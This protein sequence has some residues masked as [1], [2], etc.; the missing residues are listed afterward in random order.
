MNWLKS[1]RKASLRRKLTIAFLAVLIIPS[2]LIGYLSF[3]TAKKEIRSMLM[4]TAEENI[5]LVEYFLDR[6]I[7]PRMADADYFAKHFTKSS[8]AAEN[9]ADILKQLNQYTALHGDV[10]EIFVGTSEGKMIADT[11]YD[12]S[13]DPRNRPWYLEAS[14]NKETI[15]TE[16]YISASTNEVLV[17][18][19][20]QL[21]DGSGVI[22]IDI[23]LS[24]IQNLINQ[25]KIGK[26]GYAFLV[27]RNKKF[28]AH[29]TF[30]AGSDAQDNFY[31]KLYESDN[32]DFSYVLDGIDKEMLFTTNLLTGWKI[33]GTMDLSEV[34]SA[35]RQ[36]LINTAVILAISI[37]TGLIIV[38]FIIRSII[39]PINLLKQRAKAISEGDL[40]ATINIKTKDEIG[41][42]A[43]SFN[44]MTESLKRVVTQTTT[45]ADHVAASAEQLMASSEQTTKATEQVAAAIE[46]I[47]EGAETQTNGVQNT[48]KS[49]E[50]IA[51]GMETIAQHS[52]TVSDLTRDTNKSADAGLLK[53][54]RTVKQMNSIFDSVGKS[55]ETILTLNERS[56]EIGVILEV[57]SGISDQTNL[58]ALN[59]AIEAARAGEHGKG[60]A[61]VADEVRKLAE[62]SQQA[63]KQ[64][65]ELIKETQNDATASVEMMKNV[66]SDVE[67]G[68]TITNET[69]ITFSEIV[70]KMQNIAPQI[71]D[72]SAIAQQVSAGVQE[73]TSATNELANVAEEN[74]ATSEEVAASSEEQLASMEEIRASSKNL[75]EMAEELKE[76]VK[77]F[78]V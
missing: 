71:E 37:I 48:A 39:K 53:V 16:P 63:A 57:I 70:E 72:I 25:G 28:I 41:E 14:Q 9:K 58:L 26:K 34:D 55:N 54:E 68:L 5:I 45:N 1:L 32:G 8:L 51:K 40:T 56:K 36:M 7:Q 77:I 6:T 27:D 76:L 19:A 10:V 13:Y 29:P 50:E 78:T 11:D 24:G 59:A 62:Q 61:V 65:A 23:Q 18:V 2:I 35:A 52:I 64:V 60:F 38:I 17:T 46:Q 49:L 30:D 69:M 12:S 75:A 66:T 21:E 67:Q 15:I 3:Q 20:K 33:A 4:G 42:L 31:N 74:A 43:I 73:I 44:E 47:A 22:G